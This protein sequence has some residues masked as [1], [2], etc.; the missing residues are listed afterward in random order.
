[1]VLVDG[2][3]LEQLPMRS[4]ASQPL[5]SADGRW[6]AWSEVRAPRTDAYRRVERYR[7]VLYDVE[8]RVIANS[9]RD[10]RSV[11]WQDG[12]NGIWLRTLSNQGRLVLHRGSAGVQVLSP[13]GRPVPLGGPHVGN[14]VD[15]DGWPGGTTV[16]R[17][18]SEASVYGT[19]ARSGSFTQVGRFT[20]SWA[21][22]WSAKGS[23][24]AYTD[25]DPDEIAYWVRPLDGAS[26]RLNTPS[27]VREFRTVGW[28][29]ATAVILSS[30]DGLLEHARVAAGSLFHDDRRLR[31]GARRPA[32]RSAG[33]HAFSILTA[34]SGGSL[35]L[36]IVH[37][38]NRSAARVG[39]RA[40]AYAALNAPPPTPGAGWKYVNVQ[41][42]FIYIEQSIEERTSW[43][44]FEP[45]RA[46]L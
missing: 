38:V 30:F 43:A 11:A 19:V 2:D 32:A 21:G 36:A 35:T 15:L 10:G 27:D 37:R 42:R 33:H 29:S 45:K 23:A 8:R 7:V 44:V 28:E 1:M 17:S 4:S 13:R 46:L 22:L 6:L 3:R 34:T 40:Q 39:L 14:S 26:V 18:K 12:I 20:G 5:I 25:Y 9:F 16:W 24:Y 31:A 41:R